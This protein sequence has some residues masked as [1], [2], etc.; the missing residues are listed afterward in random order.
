[1]EMRRKKVG[2]NNYAERSCKQG[3]ERTKETREEIYSEHKMQRKTKQ[4]KRYWKKQTEG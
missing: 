3:E 2:K 4:N 1:M